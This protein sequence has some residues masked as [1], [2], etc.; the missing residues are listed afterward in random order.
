MGHAVLAQVQFSFAIAQMHAIALAIAPDLAFVAFVGLHPSA[1]AV[2]FEAV[3][4]HFI[5]VVGIDIALMVVA[6]DAQA[7]RDGAIGEYRSDADA[8]VAAEE[9]RTRF[10]FE[11]AKESVT[12]VVGDDLAFQTG[13]CDEL[14]HLD[15]LLV[16]ELQFRVV[17]GTSKGEHCEEPP[18]RYAQS[19]EEIAELGQIVDGTLVHAGDDVPGEFRVLFEGFDGVDHMFEALSMAAHPVMVIFE[20]VEADGDGAQAILAQLVEFL[21]GEQHAV[22]HHA[23]HEAFFGDFAATFGQIATHERF[24]ARSDD[25]HARRIMA[26]PDVVE[27]FQEIS[28]RHVGSLRECTAVATAMTAVEVAAQGAFPKQ[29]SQLMFLNLLLTHSMVEFQ[30]HPLEKA[31]LF[32]HDLLFVEFLQFLLYLVHLLADLVGLFA[33]TLHHLGR[34]I[35]ASRLTTFENILQRIELLLERIAL[36]CL[37][38]IIQF[39]DSSVEFVQLT[40]KARIFGAV[41]LYDLRR[42]INTS[43]FATA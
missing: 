37:F 32:S 11:A 24:A 7:S 6:A 36:G 33:I 30:G 9:T 23:P 16:R 21:F 34:A 28:D 35:H 18:F 25:H 41:S 26:G 39:V 40:T 27:H 2:S 42:A 4:P 38:G 15:E 5:E 12:A 20:A 29:L 17:G 8:C 22:G 10:T 43:I 1:V 3:L 13:L 19:D 14:E 31:E